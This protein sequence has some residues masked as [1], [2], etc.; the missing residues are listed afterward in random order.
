MI[1]IISKV[2]KIYKTVFLE[3][4]SAVEDF[5]KTLE[6]IP[7]CIGLRQNNGI[8]FLE[9]SSRLI[10]AMRNKD[11]SDLD[12]YKQIF[13]NKEYAIFK[14]LVNYNYHDQNVVIIAAGANIGYTSLYFATELLNCK[15]FAIE[16]S[17]E[18]FEIL[19]N[20]MEIN[21]VN[22]RIYQRA[23]A[24]VEGKKFEIGGNFRDSRDWS[25]TTIESINGQVDGIT[26]K[27]IINEN[28]LEYLTILKIDIEGA[29]RFLFKNGIDLGYLRITK[30]IAIEIHDE[31][32][33]REK[34][35]STLR[36]NGFI[37]FTSGELTIGIN[38][39]LYH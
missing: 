15:I 13:I 5:K 18:N 14:D 35:N 27:Q 25:I 33:I 29:E 16:P 22:A 2:K 23:L 28:K 31:F 21:S 7:G 32:N 30:L 26:I 8:Y 12:V 34:I 20:N 6:N 39:W 4:T 10:I 37:I 3:N 9:L 19:K 36:E 1:K 17:P 24:E 11:H 38:K